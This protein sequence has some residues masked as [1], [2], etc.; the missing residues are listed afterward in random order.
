MEA[1]TALA[2]V[3]GFLWGAMAVIALQGMYVAKQLPQEASEA[4]EE[5]WRCGVTCWFGANDLR[6]QDISSDVLIMTMTAAV[7][8]KLLL[9]CEP[10]VLFFCRMRRAERTQDVGDL[11]FFDGVRGR[12]LSVPKNPCKPC[13]NFFIDLVCTLNTNRT[14]EGC[15]PSVDDMIL[16]RLEVPTSY[17]LDLKKRRR[18]EAEEVEEESLLAQYYNDEDSLHEY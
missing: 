1:R 18:R 11:E 6:C 5:A 3:I 4:I 16:W 13:K 15:L 9:S 17:Y 10:P 14:A 12:P 2:V 7:G 8:S